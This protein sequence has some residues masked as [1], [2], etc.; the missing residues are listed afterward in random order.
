MRNLIPY[1]YAY[2]KHRNRSLH[3]PYIHGN[4]RQ[5][6][7]HE[8][9]SVLPHKA[10]LTPHH[11]GYRLR[12]YKARG[13]T[14]QSVYPYNIRPG[15]VVAEINGQG[16]YRRYDRVRYQSIRGSRSRG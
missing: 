1:S 4:N 14:R 10:L 6:R 9:V 16:A 11:H 15:Y 7:A 8:Q 12:A 2:R 5:S 3:R 13:Q